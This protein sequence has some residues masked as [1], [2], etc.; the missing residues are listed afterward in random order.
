MSAPAWSADLAGERHRII[1]CVINTH[2]RYPGADLAGVTRREN[3]TD[4]VR[5][6]GISEKMPPTRFGSMASL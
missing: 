5:L 6:G 4:L 3:A 2:N 1:A